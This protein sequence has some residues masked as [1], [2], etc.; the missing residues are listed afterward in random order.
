MPYIRLN[1]ETKGVTGGR[2]YDSCTPVA[3]R[4]LL[5]D[6]F[7]N[8]NDLWISHRCEELSELFLKEA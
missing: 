4:H 7:E 2:C 1:F 3:L 5:V 6:K 8:I